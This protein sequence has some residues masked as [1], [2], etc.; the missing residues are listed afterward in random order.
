M[1]LPSSRFDTILPQ[2][3][4]MLVLI[5]LILMD[6]TYCVIPISCPMGTEALRAE[7]T[8]TPA[9]HLWVP[10]GASKHPIR[11]TLQGFLHS[12]RLVEMT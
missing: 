3:H 7:W 6:P 9:L 11:I 4:D 2:K 12:L 5:H 1:S 10:A 8:A